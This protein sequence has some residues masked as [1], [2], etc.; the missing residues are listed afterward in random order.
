L[1]VPLKLNILGRFEARLPSGEPVSLPTRKTETLLAYLA[2]VPGPHS[3]DHLSNLLWG[4]RSDQQARNSLRQALNALKKLFDNIEPLPLQIERTNVNLVNQSIEIDAVNLKELVEE[5]TPKAAAQAIKLY[6]G[7]L[8]EGVAVRD[9]NGEEWLAAERD[10]FRKLAMSALES[11]LAFQLDSGEFNKAEELGEQFVSLDALNESAWRT[12]MQVYVARGDRNHALKAYKRC[13]EILNR[14]LGVEPSEETTKLL[15]AIKAGSVDAYANIVDPQ[16]MVAHESTP[17]ANVIRPE[18][19]SSIEKPSIAVLPFVNMSNDPDQEFFSDGIT[20]DIITELTRFQSL[21]V[22]A[23]NSSFAFKGQVIDITEIGKKLGVQFVVEGSVRKAGERI[24]ITAQLIEASTGNHLWAERYDRNLDD[25]FAVQDE[26]ASQIVTVI[27]GHVDIANR[28]QAERKPAMDMNAYELVLRAENILNR[29]FGSREGEQLLKQA[30]EID[31]E[32]ARVHAVLAEFYAYSVFAHALDVDEATTLARTHAE[33]AL[34]IDPG[35]AVVQAL[36]AVAYLEGGEYALASHHMD[37]AIALNPN[38][39]VVMRAAA[40]VKAYLGDYDAAV[41]WA[42]KASLCD[43]FSWDSHR[44]VYFDAH[45]LGGQY[46]LALEQFVGWQDLP[47]HNYLSQAAAFA[48]L[49]RLEEAKDALQQFEKYRPE[50]WSTVDVLHAYVRMCAKPEDGERWLE[51]F[52]KA[53]LEI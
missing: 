29:N 28:I 25:I 43:P 17:A 49:D 9:S 50:D 1:T 13:C 51:G 19:P 11:L 37:K 35:D 21:F 7:E 24:R 32:Y 33:T 34:K 52:R 45:F 3:R 22:I 2:L 27:P 8:L 53:G 46:E 10:R 23:R 16:P 48:Q 44:E 15:G 26:V 20:E 42:N 18:P 40:E 31:P 30:L 14:E 4:D 6:R 38:D 5:Q 36:L 47:L 39:H 41:E 12:L